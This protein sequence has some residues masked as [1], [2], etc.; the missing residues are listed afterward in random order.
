MKVKVGGPFTTLMPSGVLESPV[1]G[2]EITIDDADTVLVAHWKMLAKAGHAEILEEPVEV[3]DAIADP[4]ADGK[5]DTKKAV[6]EP[7]AGEKPA[8]PAKKA[9]PRAGG[10]Q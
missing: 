5:A 4:A 1:P 3:K 2:S 8:K 10:D 7:P 6:V 9:A